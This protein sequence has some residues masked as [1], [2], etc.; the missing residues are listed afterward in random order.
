[1]LENVHSSSDKGDTKWPPSV[2]P[3]LGRLRCEDQVPD[4]TGLQETVFKGKMQ[5][6]VTINKHL[7]IPNDEE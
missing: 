3:S 7:C 1:M 4:Q 5:S 6:D 2:I